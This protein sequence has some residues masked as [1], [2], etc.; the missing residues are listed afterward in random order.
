MTSKDR[1]NLND[2][3]AKGIKK[4]NILG[5][6]T[7]KGNL[8]G[9][10]VWIYKISTD[11]EGNKIPIVGLKRIENFERIRDI[12]LDEG[13]NLG[14]LIKRGNQYDTIP[15]ILLTNLDNSRLYSRFELENGYL[16]DKGDTWYKDHSDEI[17]DST[18]FDLLSNG[19][20]KMYGIRVLHSYFSR[21]GDTYHGVLVKMDHINTYLKYGIVIKPSVGLCK[22]LKSQPQSRLRGIQAAYEEF[23][24]F[25]NELK[26]TKGAEIS[27]MI[28]EAEEFMEG[29]DGIYYLVNFD[30]GSKRYPREIDIKDDILVK[31]NALEKGGEIIEGPNK[32]EIANIFKKLIGDDLTNEKLHKICFNDFRRFHPQQEILEIFSGLIYRKEQSQKEWCCEILELFQEFEPEDPSDLDEI[33]KIILEYQ[34]A[35]SE[36]SFSPLTDDRE[37]FI[38]NDDYDDFVLKD[39]LIKMMVSLFGRYT[40]ISMLRGTIFVDKGIVRFV[41]VPYNAF[42]KTIIASGMILPWQYTAIKK[43]GRMPAMKLDPNRKRNKNDILERYFIDIYT[44]SVFFRSSSMAEIGERDYDKAMIEIPA[45][46]LSIWMPAYSRTDEFEADGTGFMSFLTLSKYNIRK[47]REW[48]E[49]Q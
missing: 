24:S 14:A 38:K 34:K 41:G 28:R 37:H 7:E 30:T 11:N 36:K 17:E 32:K 31:L 3:L 16:V 19:D 5:L 13:W 18:L 35:L 33:D 43:R 21:Y 9:V 45:I 6:K 1:V 26:D 40:V 27:S 47:Y 4:E 22:D 10:Y 48:L 25:E 12:I 23:R 8:V 49:N 39:I 46:P 2:L 15:P 29:E 44:Q 20:K 42:R